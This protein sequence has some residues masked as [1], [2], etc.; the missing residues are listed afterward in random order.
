MNTFWNWTKEHKIKVIFYLL[1]FL[2]SNYVSSFF[3]T[4]TGT[5][6][7]KLSYLTSHLT[8]IFE[9]FPIALTIKDLGLALGVTSVLIL[10]VSQKEENNKTYRKG[11]EHGS[12]TWGNPKKDLEGMFNQKDDS[13]NILFS[14][15]IRMAINNEDVTD[16]KRNAIKMR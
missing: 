3:S 5:F 7:N 12:A 14:E 16:L 15:N 9:A 4:Y 8:V 6:F 13:R 2:L 10:L 11:V 1:F